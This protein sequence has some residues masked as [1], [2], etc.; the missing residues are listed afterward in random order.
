MKIMFLFRGSSMFYTNQNRLFYSQYSYSTLLTSGG[1]KIFS[2]G[3][4]KIKCFV[5]AML[6]S[7]IVRISAC[8]F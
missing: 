4:P 7:E 6:F 8:T 3:I 5:K 2:C 1:V